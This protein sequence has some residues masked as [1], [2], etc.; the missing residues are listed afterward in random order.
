MCERQQPLTLG[1]FVEQFLLRV[2]ADLGDDRAGPQRRVHDGF[3]RQPAPDFGEHRHHFDL[4]G[5]V[6]VESESEN[7]DL[8]Q[9]RPHLA[10]PAQVGVDDLV[11]ALGVIAARQQIAGGVAQQH[12]LVAQLKVHVYSCPYKPRMVDAMMVRCTSLLPP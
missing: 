8:G 9:L 6:G 4:P 7:P 12:L 10:A 5:L 2:V 3:G 1:D 11:A